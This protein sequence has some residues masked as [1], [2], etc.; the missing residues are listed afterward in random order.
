MLNIQINTTS[1]PMVLGLLS[2]GGGPTGEAD[3][4]HTIATTVVDTYYKLVCNDVGVFDATIDWGDGSIPS[5][6]TTFDDIGLAHTYAAAGTYQI[7]VSGTFPSL[8]AEFSGASNL[9]VQSVD[10]LGSV[11]WLD[12]DYA[13]RQYSNM[14]SWTAGDCDIS[15]VTSMAG[16]WMYCYDLVTVDTSGMDVSNVTNLDSLFR[17][18]T[19]LVNIDCSTWDTSSVINFESMFRG[20][21]VRE[22]INV[23]GWDTSK[24]E[25]FQLAFQGLPETGMDVVGLEGWD[26]SGING[27]NDLYLWFTQSAMPTAR[28]DAVLIA[29]VAV[30]QFTGLS[31]SFGTSTYTSG[32]AAAT[33]R[34]LLISRDSWVIIDG[35]TA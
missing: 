13:F 2:G 14:T 4:L 5:V 25:N 12:L 17:N 30:P 18:N 11:G 7:R 19:S 29:M 32:G 33:A 15:G 31:T 27:I 23:T 6:I 1:L 35:G 8:F 24:G 34:A 3:Y 10:N 22:T 21:E 20:S 28:Y 26:Y 9:L 16:F